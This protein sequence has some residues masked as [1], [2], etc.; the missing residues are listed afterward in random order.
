MA[1]GSDRVYVSLDTLRTEIRAAN[2][3]LELSLRGYM[4]D[5]LDKKA[6]LELMLAMSAQLAELSRSAVVKDGPLMATLAVVA[7][8][9]EGFARGELQPAMR[10]AVEGVVVKTVGRGRERRWTRWE[11]IL[12]IVAIVLW[13][14]TTVIALVGLFHK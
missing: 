13:L 14:L 2:G 3:E 9:W 10:G 5:E 6:P 11:R 1:N 7:H 8:E 4:V 12:A